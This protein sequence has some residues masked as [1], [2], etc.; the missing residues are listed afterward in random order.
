MFGF[1]LEF[2][3]FVFGEVAGI[4]IGLVSRQPVLMAALVLVF[5]VLFAALPV[6]GIPMQHPTEGKKQAGSGPH[7][8]QLGRLSLGVYG[9]FWQG[10]TLPK[11]P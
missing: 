4:G 1:R 8:P 11:I 7:A 3:G 5:G 10:N 2:A 9:E 6:D